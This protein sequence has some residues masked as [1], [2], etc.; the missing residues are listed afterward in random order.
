[1]G[2]ESICLVTASHIS[3]NPRIVKEA[4]ALQ[5][6]GYKVRVVSVLHDDGQYA[7]D[8]DLAETKSWEWDMVDARKTTYQS[9]LLWSKAALRQKC[10]QTSRIFEELPMGLERAYSRYVNEVFTCAAKRKAALFIAHTLPALPAAYRASILQGG[11]LAFDAEDFHR[12]EFGTERD[13]PETIR[14]TI[15]IEERYLPR[16]SHVTASSK[17]VADAYAEALNIEKPKTILNTF[18]MEER[19]GQTPVEDLSRER[20]GGEISLYWYGQTIGPDRGLDDA[21][22]A[23]PA[24]GERVHLHVRGTWSNGFKS[25]F[26]RK[27]IRLGVAKRVHHLEP[28]G[29]SQLVERAAQHDVGLALETGATV[30]REICVTNKLLTYILAGIAIVATRTTGQ[31]EVMSK[32]SEAGLTYRSGDPAALAKI[33][34]TWRDDRE[35]LLKAKTAAKIAGVSFFNWN[36]EKRE[37]LEHVRG[38][39]TKLP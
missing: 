36:C 20:H 17:G 35:T 37:L 8:R 27:A 11:I 2:A 6:A 24:L 32:A 5:E 22:D 39:L 9:Y 21:L 4:D 15:A 25:A 30:N 12:G 16:C 3:C 13:D 26:M 29:P 33:L 28:V 23:L 7:I 34:R 38:A 18:P 10:Y 31:C 1:M 14:R 19:S